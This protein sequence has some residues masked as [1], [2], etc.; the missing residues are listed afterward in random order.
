MIQDECHVALL[1]ECMLELQ[2]Q[3]FGAMHQSFGGDTLNTAIYLARAGAAR[4]LRVSYAT[5]VGDD[6]LSDGLLHRWAEEGLAL[7][8]VR[9]VPGRMPGLY[10][11][12]VDARGE[13]AFFYWREQS[14]ARAYFDTDL[15]PLEAMADHLDVLYFSGISLAILPEGGRER[16][17]ALAHTLRE[18]GAQVVFDN[19]YRPRLWPDIAVARRWYDRTYAVCSTALLTL[20]DEQALRGLDDVAALSAAAALPALEVVVKRGAAPTC[21]RQTGEAWRLVPTVPVPRVIDTTAAGD[22]FGG[23]YLAARLG[24]ANPTEAVAAG[25]ALAA[26]VIQHRGALMPR[27]AVMG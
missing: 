24:G 9:R 25:N 1:G 15:T 2:G 11:I 10:Q 20:E 21:V 23:A 3:A 8:L 22:S 19:N 4:G 12:Q 27:D 18:R 26:R 17:L 14:A 16:L 5:G 13:R 6:A 7:D